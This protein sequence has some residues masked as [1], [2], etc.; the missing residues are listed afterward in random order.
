MR[1]SAKTKLWLVDITSL[2]M[3]LT[4]GG[5]MLYGHGWGKWQSY[6]VS[7]G[8]FPDPL[9]IGNATSMALAIFAE[10][11]CSIAVMLG[12]ATRFALL[13]LITT[14]VVAAFIVHRNFPFDE[15]ELALMYMSIYI[16]MFILGPGRYSV[17]AAIMR[18]FRSSE[19]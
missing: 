3:R 16:V 8:S 4:F 7:S 12:F 13:N 14:M 17:D 2:L 9:G 5:F 1:L 10:V 18:F 11:F 15:K 6:A 19:E